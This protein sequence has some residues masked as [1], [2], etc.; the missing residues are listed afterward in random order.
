MSH[1]VGNSLSVL[2]S[3]CRNCSCAAQS[4]DELNE[5]VLGRLVAICH[6]KRLAIENAT[7]GAAFPSLM[8]ALIDIFLVKDHF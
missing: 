5:T 4:K 7:Q 2:A 3:I 1:P 8:R 6:A